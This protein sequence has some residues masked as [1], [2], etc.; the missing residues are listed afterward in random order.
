MA[1]V[2]SDLWAAGG[3]ELG[4]H[5]VLHHHSVHD[6]PV[7]RAIDRLLQLAHEQGARPHHVPVVLCLCRRLAHVRVRRP[8]VS[9]LS[10]QP[11]PPGH[12]AALKGARE[13]EQVT[14]S[15]PAPEE[16]LLLGLLTFC[17]RRDEDCTAAA[18]GVSVFCGV[19]GS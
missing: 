6:A 15:T 12:H 7:R 11:P 17:R 13:H 16:E 1:V 2:R 9:R 19:R 4:G 14:S 3:S 8:R 10:G 18:V 5:G